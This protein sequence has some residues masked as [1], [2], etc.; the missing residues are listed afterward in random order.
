VPFLILSRVERRERSNHTAPEYACKRYR[1]SSFATIL[2]L[3]NDETR[4]IA[5]QPALAL[6][7]PVAATS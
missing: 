3:P 1:F 4:R 6:P 5:I 7:S 2:N